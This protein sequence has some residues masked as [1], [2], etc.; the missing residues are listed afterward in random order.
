QFLA[1]RHPDVPQHDI[2]KL[3]TLAGAK[4]LGYGSQCGSLTPGK[5]ADVAAVAL[6]DPTGCDPVYQL[7][8][9]GNEIAGTMLAGR[10]VCGAF[11]ER[12]DTQG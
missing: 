5:R 1:D 2:L 10:W 12:E 11:T 3:G 4:A 8:D 9:A 6:A 7:L